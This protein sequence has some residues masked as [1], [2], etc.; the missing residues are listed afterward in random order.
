M[1]HSLEQQVYASKR[2]AEGKTPFPVCGRKWGFFKE[3]RILWARSMEE[4]KQRFPTLE[5]RFYSS[6]VN[7][8]NSDIDVPDE[9]TARYEIKRH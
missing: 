4:V 6:L 7:Q 8:K 1:K 9:F 5:F 2:E 3:E